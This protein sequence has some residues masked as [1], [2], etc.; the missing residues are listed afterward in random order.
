MIAALY[1][2]ISRDKQELVNQKA[3]LLEYCDK[4]GYS[5]SP[6][7]IYSDI[8][9]GDREKRPGFD[10][11]FLDAHKRKFDLLIFWA[12]D[13]FSRAGTPHT[14]RKLTELDN[15]N[16]QW[17]SF[18]EP[19]ISTMG[20]F[21]HIAI[22]FLSTFAKLE[23]KRISD[24]TKAGLKASKKRHLVGKRGKDKKPRKRRGYFKE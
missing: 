9:T 3:E 12:L 15:L 17:H 5:V 8:V 20:E 7:N 21:R 10:H 19:N 24:R 14:I 16:V 11:M 1:I 13:R 6:N 2:R 22:A 18:T 4:K 23:K